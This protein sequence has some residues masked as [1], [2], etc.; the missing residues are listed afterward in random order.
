MTFPTEP[1]EMLYELQVGS[2]DWINVTP[3]T[4]SLRQNTQITW[5]VPGEYSVA[6]PT[7]CEFQLNN[8]SGKYSPRNPLSPYADKIGRNTPV[9]VSIGEG[10]YGM[11]TSG[12]ADS[13]GHAYAGDHA[14][15]SITGDID[16]RVDLELLTDPVSGAVS[17]WTAGNFD[18]ASKFDNSDSFR[19]WTLIVVGGKPRLCWF[20]A[21]T[22]ASVRTATATVAIPGPAT[23][24]RAIRA[25]L[26]VN[27]GASGCTVTFYTAPNMNGTWTQLGATV[28]AAGTTSIFDGGARV[29]VGGAPDASTW[30]WTEPP[31]ATFYG[32]QLRNGIG[33]T[34]VL[35]PDFT[36]PDLDAA[37]F[38]ASDGF[39]WTLSGDTDAARIWYGDVDVRACTESSSFP[40]RWDTSGND[41]WVPMESA[42]ILRRLGLGQDAAATGLRDWAMSQD[43]QPASYFPLSGAEG[44]TYSV[45][46]G[47]VGTN[48]Y[49]FRPEVV[50][51]SL[52]F[53]P[54]DVA[55]TYGKDMGPYLGTGMEINATGTNLYLRGDVN[56]TADNFTFDFVFQ[57][58]YNVVPGTQQSTNI[59]VMDLLFWNYSDDRFRLR[60]QNS[61]DDG[62]AQVTF[63][64][65]DDGS[66]STFSATAVLAALQ[67]N[68]IHAVRFQVRSSGGSYFYELWV[69]GVSVSTGSI[70]VGR[71][72]NGLSLYQVFYERYLG[73]TIVN[74]GHFMVWEGIP[75]YTDVPDVG[76]MVDAVNGYAGELAGD[77]IV[78]IAELDGL[79]LT[80][81]GDTADTLAM[82]TQFSEARLTQ[83]RDA[84]NTDMGILGE[85]RRTF[86]LEYRTRASMVGQTP[87]LT[88]SYASGHIIPPFE[89]TDDDQLT[90]NDITATRREGDSFRYQK[91]DG[92]L[93]ILEPPVGVGRYH[94]QVEINV[95]NDAMLPG[96]AAWLVNLGTVDAARYPAVSVDLGILAAA[97]LD[98]AARAVKFGDLLVVEDMQELGVYEPV[99]LLVLG[100]V[101][102]ISDGAF[103][104]TIT[105]NCAPYQGY[106]ASVYATDAST[107]TA[108]Y[109]TEGCTL[110][111]ALGTLSPSLLTTS[112]GILWTTDSAA[113]PFDIMVGGERMTVTNVTGT[114]NPQTLTVTRSVNGVVKA[115]AAGAEVRLADPAYYSL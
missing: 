40:N 35:N 50:N 30:T 102:T 47:R 87:A 15:N 14:L 73:Q 107:G 4:F 112:E 10:A 9:R 86:G 85:S 32:F 89:P 98:E 95:A 57:S 2:T 59:G 36:V 22:A 60:L 68:G 65:G 91:T 34:A 113:R 97:G 61:T 29:R 83:L 56:T 8:I 96:V 53:V 114:S 23:G 108:R 88:L 70:A 93:S 92:P 80:V 16:I 46:I 69:D 18:L 82:G 20:S 81:V 41:A 110:T 62:T 52:P 11:V 63:F 21:G 101:E 25:T 28:I 94:D 48:S 13:V 24:R 55:T 99:R 111:V 100:G 38:N 17:S 103:K 39:L 77:R 51:S 106:E 79:P 76:V 58:P 90:K 49:R 7:T 71:A 27:N 72:W 5:G 45:N 115:H 105:W 43:P 84:E 66:S 6:G 42:G 26:D 54:L 1:R 31:S 3:D 19:S 67:D 78:R 44:T 75:A 74:V 104:H 33:G 109:D 64:N 12:V 37:T